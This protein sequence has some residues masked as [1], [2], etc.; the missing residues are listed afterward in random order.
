MVVKLLY[1]GR[2]TI[3]RT[4]LFRGVTNMVTHSQTLRFTNAHAYTSPH[5]STHL[6]TPHYTFAH[7]LR[8]CLYICTSAHGHSSTHLHTS[9]GAFTHV[10][11]LKAA[12][13]HPRPRNH[14]PARGGQAAGCSLC[15]PGAPRPSSPRGSPPSTH[16]PPL[17]RAR[18]AARRHHPAELI[19]PAWLVL[20]Q[21]AP[22]GSL[23]EVCEKLQEVCEKLRPAS[24]LQEPRTR[25]AY[26]YK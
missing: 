19:R 21:I 1:M 11:A 13:I 6:H 14:T 26:I 24:S 23:R 4:R 22:R 7:T 5:I 17:N 3:P 25:R 16:A 18:A 2:K 10:R 15:D 8:K 9:A 12:H 20:A